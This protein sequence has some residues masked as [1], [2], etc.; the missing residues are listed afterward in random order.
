MKPIK[1]E[2]LEV[3]LR[4]AEREAAL[5]ANEFVRAASE[6]R[7]AI[8]AALEMEQWVAESCRECL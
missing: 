6:E 5:L 3:I 4:R 1:D 2:M 7:E 8:L